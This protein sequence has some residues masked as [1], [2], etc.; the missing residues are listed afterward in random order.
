[1]NKVL[2]LASLFMW[3]AGSLAQVTFDIA[4]R[5]LPI[6]RNLQFSIAIEGASN[7]TPSFPDGLKANDFQLI[8]RSPNTSFST[9][10][11]NGKMSSQKSYTYYLKPKREGTFVFPAQKVNVDGKIYQS[12]AVKVTVSAAETKVQTNSR[13]R[14]SLFDDFFSRSPFEPRQRATREAEVFAELV[15]PKNKF[16]KGEAIPV[17]V[18]LYTRGVE[19]YPQRSAMEWPEMADFWIEEV[20]AQEQQGRIVEKNGKRYQKNFVGSRLLYATKTGNVTIE[21]VE[22]NLAVST[23]GFMADLQNVK[24][25]TKARTLHI[26]PLPDKNKPADFSGAV[27]QFQLKA[28]IDK[29]K[30]AIGETLSYKLILSGKGNFSA[31]QQLRTEQLK[32]HFEVFDGGA[33]QSEEQNGL[34][35]KKTWVYALVPRNEGTYTLPPV[36][37]SFFDIK[38]KSYQTLSTREYTVDVEAGSRLPGQ[39]QVGVIGPAAPVEDENLRYIDFEA[40]GWTHQEREYMKPDLL[41]LIC[42]LGFLFNMSFLVIRKM[43]ENWM[44]KQEELR[45]KLAFKEFKGQIKKLKKRIN[46]PNE[47][48]HTDLSQAI[49]NYFGAKFMRSGQGISLDE[50]ERELEKKSADQQLHRDLVSC[51]ESC[52]FARFTSSSLSSKEKL[53]AL[54][55]ETLT[56][57]EEVL[58]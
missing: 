9:S 52:D 37:F 8:S 2:F 55:E 26:V 12:P 34:V 36:A 29:A 20:Q 5:N 48:F 22:F 45:P 41:Y 24:R 21:P 25:L 16:Y 50:I 6:N 44:G 53:L 28:E 56:K 18:F 39:Q 30:I 11:V 58:K 4:P 51:I 17:Q 57:V 10:I 40:E 1:M 49:M 46:D 19:I 27:G 43:R 7:R 42:G 33:P 13:G 14:R 31:I 23:G 32:D 47:V 35:V 54:A 3:A 15:V 38:T